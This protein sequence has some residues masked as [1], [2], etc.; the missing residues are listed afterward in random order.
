M[1]KI[2]KKIKTIQSVDRACKIL[3]I[4]SNSDR[5]INLNKIAK[6]INLKNSTVYHLINTL[7]KNG[8][9]KKI[10]GKYNLDV[11]CLKIGNTYLKGL[12]LLNISKPLLTELMNKFNENIYLVMQDEHDNENFFS[13]LKLESTH[14][15]KPTKVATNISNAHATAIGKVFLS[16]FSAQ[17]ISR[18]REKYNFLKYTPNTII[19]TTDLLTELSKV[20]RM[21]YALDLEESEIGINCVAVPIYNHDEKII[22]SIGIS[23]PTQRF[24]KK[25]F[26]EIIYSLKDTSLK[27]SKELGY[28]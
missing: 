23:I 8:F 6:T 19:S 1:D 3:D 21:K 15:V 9:I 28:E 25:F 12:S 22:A 14:S 20:R 4:L 10:N 13:L 17:D 7:V 2:N 24:T 11:K 26:N 18:L 27:I 5:A 16:S